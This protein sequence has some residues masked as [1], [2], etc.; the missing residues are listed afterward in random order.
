MRVPGQGPDDITW[1]VERLG[2]APVDVFPALDHLTDFPTAFACCDNNFIM[3]GEFSSQQ[4]KFK[5]KILIWP[6]DFNDASM[7]SLPIHSLYRLHENLL[8]D[9]EQMSLLLLSGSRILLAEIWPDTDAVPRSIPV[10]GTPTRVIF[11]QTYQCLI[12]ALLVDNKPT[13]AFVD[14]QSGKIISEVID[15]DRNPSDFA[16][17]LGQ[18]GDRITSLKEWIYVKDG[19]TFPFILATTKSGCLL[20]IS[21]SMTEIQTDE[22]VTKRIEYWT[23]NRKRYPQP[24]Y[25]IAADGDGIVFCVD[26]ELH[27]EVLDLAEKK[28]KPMK[29]FQLGSPATSLQIMD[30][31]TYALTTTHSL[32]VID[33]RSEASNN[34]MTLLHTDRI[35]RST[36]HMIDVGASTEPAGFWPIFML[37]DL[38]GGIAGVWVPWGQRNREFTVVFEGVLPTAVRRFIRIQSHP[39]RQAAERGRRY[40]TI[41]SSV[42]NAETFGVSVSGSLY[43]FTL[44]SL[45]LW[46]FIYLIQTLAQQN[47]DIY[48]L[49]EPRMESPPGT[50]VARAE[51]VPDSLPDIRPHPNRMHI[52]GELVRRCLTQRQLESIVDTRPLFDLYCRCLDKLENGIHTERFRDSFEDAGEQ[53]RSYFSLGYDVLE[54][55]FAPVL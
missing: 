26:T 9:E 21:A 5:S 20:I 14:P 39:L 34:E 22:G 35:S 29:S 11:S 55:L 23:R 8:K 2:V 46:Q 48:P 4:S 3:L 15:K 19:N 37:S 41:A 50:E 25:S 53:K 40:G 13:L 32:L 27:W 47:T 43:H 28:L 52:H 17:G 51:S 33:H 7:P 49:T 36:M 42:D 12:V 44:L 1:H 10:G 30:G 54:Y 6:T 45:E 31:K 16:S 18:A 38:A 24:I